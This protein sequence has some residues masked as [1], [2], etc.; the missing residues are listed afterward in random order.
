MADLY[1]SS[2]KILPG[3]EPALKLKNWKEGTRVD[4]PALI[5]SLILFFTD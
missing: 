1:I 3:S 4:A 5:F 2:L